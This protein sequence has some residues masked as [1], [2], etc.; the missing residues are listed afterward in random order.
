MTSSTSSYHKLCLPK[1]ALTADGLPEPGCDQLFSYVPLVLIFLSQFVLGI[2]NTLYYSLGQSYLDD[3]TKKTNTPI[4]LGF[5][6]SI[7]M[8]GPMLGFFLSFLALNLYIDPS[9]TPVISRNDPR[10][11]GAWWLGWIILGI[12][13]ILFAVL[14]GLFPRDL[15]KRKSKKEEILDKPVLEN[16]QYDEGSEA[17]MTEEKKKMNGDFQQMEEEPPVVKIK[18]KMKDF[19]AAL[20]RLITNKLLMFNIFS[21]V[22]YILGMGGF[23][24][25]MSKYIEV[26]FNKN[27]ADSTI[28]AG[29]LNLLGMVAG[30]LASGYYISKRKPSSSKLLF[31]NVFIG[32]LYMF[33]QISYMFL[34]CSDDKMPMPVNGKFNLAEDCN[35]NCACD[36]VPYNPV[37]DEATGRTFFSACHAGCQSWDGSG[38]VRK[39]FVFLVKFEE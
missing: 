30:L 2:G 3:N 31:W 5:A 32:V 20:R 28:L 6:F 18:P 4:M 13:M 34:S 7:R 24:T 27:K 12:A 35:G 10:W 33:G 16:G 15:P 36:N 19:P 22:F 23:M 39:Y 21:A 1:L 9:M 37:C 25:F 38:Q 11:M 14:V 29:P 26:Q 8:V 17:L